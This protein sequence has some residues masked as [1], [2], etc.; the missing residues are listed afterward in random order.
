MRNGAGVR[1]PTEAQWE[2]AARGT[3]GRAYPWGHDWDPTR[4][5]SSVGQQRTYSTAP[6]GATPE[7]SSPYGV[8]DMAGNVWEWCADWY[9]VFY[10]QSSPPHN[11]MGPGH[12]VQH[13][14]RGGSWHDLE[15]YAFRCAYRNESDPLQRASYLGFR[16]V[17]S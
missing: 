5:C 9:F 3:D 7:G 17:S 16:C 11:P 6:V 4:C 13:V 12:A 1:L 8:Q 14:I 2:K 10:Y 15:S